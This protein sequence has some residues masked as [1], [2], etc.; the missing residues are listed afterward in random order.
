MEPSLIISGVS[1]ALALPALV[2]SLNTARSN[3]R[4]A[5]AAEERLREE[6]Q[7]TH[8]RLGPGVLGPLTFTLEDGSLFAEVTVPRAYRVQAEGWIGNSYTPL[9]G[10]P[11]VLHPGMPY[12]LHVEHWPADRGK[13]RTEE[14]RFKLWPP[15]P[16]DGDEL[17]WT[18]PCDRITGES[19]D[20]PGHWE[21]RVPVTY[22]PPRVPL[23]AYGA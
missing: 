18:C 9:A 7:A 3:R 22:Q 17:V 5:D 10:L 14:I 1:A 15:L 21:V 12:R 23:V 11:L 6:R 8:E 16:V 2:I 4:M 13:P 20:R 19:Q